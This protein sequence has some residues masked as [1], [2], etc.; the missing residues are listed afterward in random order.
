MII[1]L[2]FAFLYLIHLSP[3]NLLRSEHQA[4]HVTYSSTS[5]G[6]CQAP[7]FHF[8]WYSKT[9]TWF[10]KCIFSFE[11]LLVNILVPKMNIKRNNFLSL[12]TDFR[13]IIAYCYF[14]HSLEILV[15]QWRCASPPTTDT[16][17]FPTRSS[18][19]SVFLNKNCNYLSH[20]KHCNFGVVIF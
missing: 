14:P 6:K 15:F 13:N 19:S 3:M 2:T 18:M 7:S 1:I 9:Q 12:N 8:R 17:Q 10:F 4:S 16:G 20:L 5:C 11:F